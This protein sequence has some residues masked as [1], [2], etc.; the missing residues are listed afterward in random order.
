MTKS[1]MLL[2]ATLRDGGLGLEDAYINNISKY[3]YS[4]KQRESIAKLNM[5][6]GFD[7]VELGSIEISK[8]DKSC[9]SIYQNIE[10]ISKQIPKKRGNTM[11]VGM[12]RGPD[13]QIEKIPEHT[14][15]LLDG[16]RIIIRYSELQK[17]LDFCNS[18][19]KKGYK[20]F[21]QP[22]LTMR[23][24]YE[25]LIQLIN[26]ANDMHAYALYFVDSY[27]Y[28]ESKDVIEIYN[29]F[30]R[31]L[32]G[33]IKIGF[34]AHNNM[35]LA[36]A[37]AIT[38]IENA[39]KREIILDSCAT[40][41]GQGT[42]NLQTEIIANYLNCNYNKKY[43][44]S[45]ELEVCE[46]V[47]SFLKDN[48]WGYSVTRLLPAIHKVAYKYA[49]VMRNKYHLSFNQMNKLFEN[50]P[51]DLKQ[52]YTENDLDNYLKSSGIIKR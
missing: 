50:M 6:A 14:S 46:I 3:K 26:S 43:D 45:K 52:R 8:E 36:F 25:Q 37:N 47:S 34:H 22:M 19:A 38:F 29:L 1:I 10:E 44:Y 2:D 31:F 7:I 39:K 48:I 33:N 16:V 21:I 20:V 4:Q 5:E 9:F 41:M 28:M 49:V 42:G 40:G 24:S 27:G 51:N 15:E 13:T 30:D 11:Y 32:D 23:Y 12:F 35:N 18:L 17:S